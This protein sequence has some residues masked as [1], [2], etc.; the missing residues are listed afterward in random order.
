M[1]FEPKTTVVIKPIIIEH[2]TVVLPTALLQNK[3]ILIENGTISALGGITRRPKGAVIIEAG[4]CFVAPGFID[5]HIHGS[6]GDIFANEARF[7]TTSIIVAQSCA[8]PL[9]LIKKIRAAEKFVIK[10][11]FGANLLGVR[12][13]GPYIS[14]GKAG[15]QDRR[16]I[17]KPNAKDAAGFI[18]ECGTL[19]RM[20]TVAPEV[21]G[22]IPIVKFLKRNGI[23]ASVGHSDAT[24]D[25]ALGGIRSG[26]RHATHIFNAMRRIAG[27]EPGVGTAALLSDDVIAEVIPD[28]IHVRK[29][30][31]SL[32]IKIKGADKVILVT[33]SVRAEKR[34]GVEKKGGV[35]KFKDGTIAGS[36]LTMIGALKNCV[37]GCGIPL[38]DAVKMMTANPARLL[39]INRHKGT[40][41]PGMD[42]DIVIF[43]KNFKVKKTI[44]G[45][46]IICAG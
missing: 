13:E 5:T 16:Y 31:L 23:I 20:M 17:K 2:G 14:R 12:L 18:K 3:P 15:A 35:Y 26:I 46:E 21:S 43:D 41:A 22:A 25:E 37:E 7:G 29:E 9:E 6:P 32:L 42:A 8:A 19:L 1:S 10:S 27:S 28:L 40:I 4:G 45:G 44:I 38:A 24:Y 34:A 33:D 11:P 39:G 36:A 30:L